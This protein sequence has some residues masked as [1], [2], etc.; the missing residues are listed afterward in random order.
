MRAGSIPKQKKY[1]PHPTPTGKG[2]P[3]SQDL[4]LL[5]LLF[6]FFLLPIIFFA[7]S[8]LNP[9]WELIKDLSYAFVLFLAGVVVLVVGIGGI[10]L[11]ERLGKWWNKSTSE[12]S[13]TTPTEPDADEQDALVSL[14]PS[15][16]VSA[17]NSKPAGT[18][19]DSHGRKGLTETM[20]KRRVN[21]GGKGKPERGM[22]DVELV[23]LSGSS[24]ARR[25]TPPPLPRR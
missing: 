7:P 18:E 16:S 3:L 21:T 11:Y 5:L 19:L 9:I 20:W 2:A 13:T 22:D 10:L 8:F 24:S 1:H 12:S 14:S 4:F 23:E 25:R 15:S 17:S 6:S